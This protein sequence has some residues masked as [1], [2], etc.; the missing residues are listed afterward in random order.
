MLKILIILECA[1]CVVTTALLSRLL[2]KK[3]KKRVAELSMIAGRLCC[4]IVNDFAVTYDPTMAHDLVLSHKILRVFQ[5]GG[6]GGCWS[7]Q[8]RISAEYH[9]DNDI[10][11]IRSRIDHVVK[12]FSE[13]K[14]GFVFLV[15][16]EGS[17]KEKTNDIVS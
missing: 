12:K 4:V 7:D 2:L 10:Y 13:G 6:C 16:I 11:M 5:R 3:R 1:A 14:E 17:H 15:T 9:G 8:I